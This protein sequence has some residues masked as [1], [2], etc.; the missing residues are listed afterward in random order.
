MFSAY[1]T[2]FV[3]VRKARTFLDVYEVFLGVFEKNKEK[4]ARV[5]MDI[6]CA[7]QARKPCY[8]QIAVQPAFLLAPLHLSE[9]C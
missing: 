6:S 2:G 7:R 8:A 1:F 3:R 9:F 4:K 5:S